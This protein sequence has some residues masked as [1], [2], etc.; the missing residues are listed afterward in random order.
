MQLNHQLG[1]AFLFLSFLCSSVKSMYF[2]LEGNQQKCFMEELSKGTV[3]NGNYQTQEFDTKSQTYR[4]NPSSTLL[5]TIDEIFDNGHRVLNQR[6]GS[7]GRFTFTAAD[8]GDHLICVMATTRNWFSKENTKLFFDMK[9]GDNVFD[10]TQ[11]EDAE[12]EKLST[13]NMKIR[14]LN[15]KV[16]SIKREQ[17][18]QREHEIEFRNQSEAT[19]SHIMYWSI[20]QFFII[21]GTCYWQMR[22]LKNFFTVKKLV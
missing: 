8:S 21:I 5:I 15:S 14:D 20:I 17:Q 3:I 12:K 13:I 11:K 19:N 16:A 6:S 9:F 22:H 10:N 4:E 18:Y 1:I 7:S 2:Y